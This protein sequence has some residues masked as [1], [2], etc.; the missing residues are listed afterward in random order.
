MIKML[1]KLMS[2]ICRY[3]SLLTWCVFVCECMQS[4]LISFGNEH[5]LQPCFA[6]LLNGS[7]QFSVKRR[8]K[9]AVA[10]LV[11]AKITPVLEAGKGNGL[12]L[13]TWELSQA[14][15]FCSFVFCWCTDY[16]NWG[17]PTVTSGTY[18][19]YPL[20]ILLSTKPFNAAASPFFPCCTILKQSKNKGV[21]ASSHSSLFDRGMSCI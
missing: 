10:A 6:T 20:P 14:S 12:W 5:L 13:Q 19:T 16:R 4:N 3:Y 9:L 11:E 8:G 1:Y 21:L 17:W 15:W 7:T 2:C 18:T